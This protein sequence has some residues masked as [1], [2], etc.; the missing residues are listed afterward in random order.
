MLFLFIIPLR[1]P[2]AILFGLFPMYRFQNSITSH[3]D[4]L[5]SSDISM[6]DVWFSGSTGVWIRASHLLGRYYTTWAMSSALFALAILEIGSSFLTRLAWTVILFYASHWFWDDKHTNM[7]SFFP[8][9]WGLTKLV[10]SR[11]A[12]NPILPISPTPIASWQVSTISSSCWLRTKAC[13][14]LE[15]LSNLSQPPK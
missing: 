13:A 5:V 11:L 1:K 7:S 8:L 9:R 12:W 3:S 6:K 15:L 2:F 10:M 14:G 4:I